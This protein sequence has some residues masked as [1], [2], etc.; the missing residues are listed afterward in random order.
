MSDSKILERYTSRSP[1]SRQ[2]M[3]GAEPEVVDSFAAFGW[4]RGIKE[5]CVML[6]LRKK[7]GHIQAIGYGWIERIDFDPA[8]GITLYFAGRKVLIRGVN[9]NKEIRPTVRLLE[10]L[11][12]HR[13]PWI[14]EA[15]QATAMLSAAHETV[16]EE[17]L[18]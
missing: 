9:L 14:S 6:E 12:K 17:I 4:L 18:W 7:T 10:G 16:V 11:M 8:S 15:D 2:D 3:T 13:V 1:D 5:R